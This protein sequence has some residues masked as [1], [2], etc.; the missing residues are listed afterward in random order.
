MTGDTGFDDVTID[1]SERDHH[2]A[3]DPTMHALSA[4]ALRRARSDDRDPAFC[5]ET[6][7]RLLLA[8]LEFS[9]WVLRR[10]EKVDFVRDRTVTR[11]ISIELSVR[12]DAPVFVDA[13]G[14]HFWLVPLSVMCRRNLINLD[15]RDEHGESILIPGIRMTQQL[16]QSI[17]LAAAATGPAMSAQTRELIRTVTVGRRDEVQHAVALIQGVSGPPPAQPNALMANSTFAAALERLR[18]NFTLYVFL[19][20]E[21]GRHRLIR[22]SFDEPLNWTLTK[23]ELN[24][25]GPDVWDYE[26]LAHKLKF[27]TAAG[28]KSA[29]GISPKRVRFQ[30]PGAENAASYHFEATAPHGLRIVKASLLAGRP[31]DPN[32]LVGFDGIEG[33]APTVGLHVIEVPNG[34]LCRAQLD[35]RVTSRGWLTTMMISCW[36]VFT[37]LLSVLLHERQRIDQTQATGVVVLLI[38]ISAGV[39]TLIAQR[40]AG[41]LAARMMAPLR[42]LG[43]LTTSLPVVAAGFLVY[44][45]VD[46]SGW[47]EWARVLAFWV[48]AIV[49]FV[50]A[51][52]SSFA[53]YHTWKDE[54]ADA[55][56]SPWD[57]AGFMERRRSMAIDQNIGYPNAV[58]KL[59]F[60]TPALGIRSAEAYHWRYSWTD[61]KQRQAVDALRALA[62][63]DVRSATPV[64]SCHPFDS[65]C[66]QSGRCPGKRLAPVTA[67]SGDGAGPDDQ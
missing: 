62:R 67:R 30:V 26:P 16:D 13:S 25:V 59:G 37:V 23:P 17:L 36:V 22:M 47:Q 4:S 56:D 41:G 65:A 40:D 33:H 5:I 44:A 6:G 58:H 61:V 45:S 64:M 48:F 28:L 21:A 52:V 11:R 15:L 19:A 10:V 46:Q 9:E 3:L 1:L 49:S 39:A 8:E 50:I 42:A 14:K 27:R 38:T 12:D 29:F 34:S 20:E 18:R 24:Q 53:W 57:M 60:D 54:R 63:H 66:G 31:N 32:E 51:V 43:A 7:R 2:W 55:G 35:L